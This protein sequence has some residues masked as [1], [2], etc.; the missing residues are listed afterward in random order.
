MLM[1]KM[2]LKYFTKTLLQIYSRISGQ[3][4]EAFFLPCRNAS[5]SDFTC[6]F[7]TQFYN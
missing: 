3:V 7:A 6:L 4:S 2:L 1:R 5:S